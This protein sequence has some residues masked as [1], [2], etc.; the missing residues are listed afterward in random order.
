MLTAGLLGLLW[1]GDANARS[2]EVAIIGAHLPELSDEQAQRAAEALVE[3]VGE[4][5]VLDPVEPGRV[6]GRLAGREALVVEG[7]FLEQ[8]RAMLEEGRVLYDR[9]EF[10][11]AVSVLEEAVSALEDGLAGSAESKDLIDALLILGLAHAALGEE[12]AARRA[13]DRVVVLEPER[14]LDRVNYPPKIVKLFNEVRSMTLAQP[15][16]SLTVSGSNSSVWVDGRSQGVAPVQLDDLLPG[17]HYVLVQDDAGR[18]DFTVLELVADGAETFRAELSERMIAP[19]AEDDLGLREQTALLY[20]SLGE[21]IDT[22]LILLAGDIGGGEV[23]LQLYEP[24]TGNFSE[25]IRRSAGDDPVASL[26]LASALLTPYVSDAGTLK[27]DLVSSQ[28]AGLDINANPL[29]ASMLLDPEPI[30]ETIV[31][32]GTPWY[33]WAGAGAVVA[34]GAAGAAVFLTRD[35]D[36]S[37]GTILVNI[38]E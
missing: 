8:G 27:A 6:R 14:E 21:H 9:A 12:P 33:I 17:T 30:V 22:D 29:L 24:R 16:S 1:M 7:I 28:V 26:V 19:T 10:E 5:R 11:S 18:R 3:A 4:L 36:D 15:R 37:T 34:G 2:A 23:G 20:R 35:V 31:E 13:F 38:P 32:R 25:L